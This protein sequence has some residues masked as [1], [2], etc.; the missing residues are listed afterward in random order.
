[1]SGVPPKEVRAT[2]LPEPPFD[3]KVGRTRVRLGEEYNISHTTVLK[4]GKYSGALDELLKDIPDLVPKILAGEV[5]IS[6][7]N[8]IEMSRLSE[9]N[10]RRLSQHLSDDAAEFK[11]YLHEILPRR[12]NT[13]VKLPLPIPIGS[14]KDMPA[15]D[16][17]AELSSLTLTVPSWVRSIER[18]RSV[19]NIS[20]ITDNARRKLEKELLELRKTI[21]SMLADIKEKN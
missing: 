11:G 2:M 9:Q 7:E 20:E 14:V 6:H 17:D 18:A 3:E 19:T 15:Y 8:I 10:K 21:D 13:A 12:Q 16:P 5:K 1:M 4:Y